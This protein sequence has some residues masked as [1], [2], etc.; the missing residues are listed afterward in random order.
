MSGRLGGG[1]RSIRTGT[2]V[3]PSLT[4]IVDTAAVATRAGGPQDAILLYQM[5]GSGK[6]I[7]RKR[8][9]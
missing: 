6:S 3:Q 2:V 9:Q 4:L 7:A 5:A 8:M 1:A